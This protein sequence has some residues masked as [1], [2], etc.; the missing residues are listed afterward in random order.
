MKHLFMKL[1]STNAEFGPLGLLARI[2]NWFLIRLFGLKV[3]KFQD[4][5]SNRVAKQIF[6]KCELVK[7]ENGYWHLSPMPT[8]EKLAE[9]YRSLYWVSRDGKNYGTNTRDLVHYQI[10]KSY[11]PTFV[12]G[13]CFLNFGA[14]HGGVSHLAWLSQMNVV[15]VEPSTIPNYY[16]ER[17]RMFQSID[18]VPS[19]CADVVYGSH[20]LEHVQNIE[21]FM[22]EIRRI[23][24][25]NGVMFWE[26][27]NADCES[28][29]VVRGKIDIPHTYYFTTHFFDN[30]F[31]E[32]I[33][34]K[35][36]EQSQRFNTIE[37]WADFENKQGSV[38]RAIGRLGN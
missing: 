18:D 10:L 32:V 25:P 12:K 21:K 13:K 16:D 9:Y 36:Y 20:S 7:S 11:V 14:G 19:N 24:A 2:V 6:A 8:E 23:L 1:A 30:W 38:I 4:I 31:D 5:R 27:P 37:K 34:N 35:G 29:G 28:N 33:L 22:E 17:W 15:N 3:I 26:V